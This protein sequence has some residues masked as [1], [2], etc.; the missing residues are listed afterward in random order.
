MKKFIASAMVL[1]IFCNA[2]AQEQKE[3]T[4]QQPKTKLEQFSAKTGVVF[5]RGFQEIGTVNGLYATSVTVEVKEFV[6]VS[7][8]VKQYGIT[9]RVEE[10]GRLDKHHTS[11]I[12]YD[13]I[14][15]LM[16][17]VDYI[18][19]VEPTVTLLDN[20][21][22]DYSTRGDLK[23]ST[24][25]SDG[26]ILSAV[27]S[28]KIGSTTAYLNIEELEKLKLLIGQAKTKIDEIKS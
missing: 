13:E 14:E 17:G 4:T 20:F 3:T 16:K 18:Q 15:S 2:L 5:I 19:S 24:F 21:Q 8:G 25:S 27:K 7:D 6:N 23:V 1:S 12:D 10:K 11:F 28:G 22:A 9:V 26:K